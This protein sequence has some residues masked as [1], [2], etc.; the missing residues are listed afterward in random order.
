LIGLACALVA[1]AAASRGPE[2]RPVLVVSYSSPRALSNALHGRRLAVRTIPALDVAE[3][4]PTTAGFAQAV[5]EVR[6][7]TVSRP[8]RRASAVEPAL[9]DTTAFGAPFEWQYGAAHLDAVPPSI[10]RAVSAVTIA[11]IDTGADLTAPDIAAKAPRTY[12]IR[13]R[14]T[15]VRDLNGHGTFVASLAAGSVTN[16]AGIAGF[17]GDAKLLVIK[18]GRDDGTLSDFD[19]ASA[20]VYAVDHGAR[21]INLSVGGTSTSVVERRGIEYAARHGV[22]VVAAAGN[23]HDAGNPVEYPAA[24]VQ[25]VGSRGRGG[26]GLAVGASTSDGRRASFSNTGSQLS[27]LA[28]GADVFGAVSSLSPADDYPRS[29]LPASGGGLY[30]FAS[31]TSFAAPEVAGAAA[32][33]MAANPLLRSS[34]VAEVLKQTASNH[35]SWTPDNGYGILDAGAAVAAAQ[36]RAAVVVS[37]ARRRG[38]VEVRWI[39]FAAS[40][41]RVTVRVDAA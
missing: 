2:T 33:V 16:G 3:V 24:L 6:G 28:P 14:T 26:S 10:L 40:H 1:S 4:Q 15:D 23:D 37:G 18:A 27:L 41:Y 11:V 29:D 34:E 39:A 30:G 5:R 9:F 7:V 31:G 22:L 38:R 32:L 13:S 12:N 17:G 8:V 20:I 21:V 19:E 35:G 36:R 25:P